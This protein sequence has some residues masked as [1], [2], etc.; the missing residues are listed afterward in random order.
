M[1]FILATLAFAVLDIVSSLSVLQKDTGL[2]FPNIAMIEDNAKTSEDTAKETNNV[3]RRDVIKDKIND[4]SVANNEMIEAA[5]SSN[6]VY[7]PL[8]VYR[9]IQHSKRRIT[10]FNSFAG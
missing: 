5:E 9:R 4:S 3:N 8:F 10:M 7:R 1:L 2:V 6:L